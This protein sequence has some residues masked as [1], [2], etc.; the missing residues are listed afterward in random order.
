L[1]KTNHINSF[2][3]HQ[4]I[5]NQLDSSFLGF[6]SYDNAFLN[7]RNLTNG[8]KVYEGID[9]RYVNYSIF[10]KEDNACKFYVNPC[11]I[12]IS[13]PTPIKFHIAEGPFDCLSIKYNLRKDFNQ[14]IY[15]AVTGSGY[16]GLIR[17]FII[18]LRM[19][20]LEIHL[21]ADMDIEKYK[22]LDLANFL[23]PFKYKFYLHRNIMQGQKDMGVSID[24]IKESIERIK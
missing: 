4:N 24:K 3:R 22:I 11:Q 23:S 13:N 6:I 1:I 12:D 16:K 17:Y 8:G 15:A 9:K 14:S 21:Y 7:M 5:I 10:G 2:T 18:T 19:M 20:N